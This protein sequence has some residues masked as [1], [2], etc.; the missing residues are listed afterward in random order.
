MDMMYICVY[1]FLNGYL[2]EEVYMRPPPGLSSPSGL[3]YHLRRALYGLKQS[4]R[5]WY[6]H[7][8]AV[9]LQIGFQ[10]SIHDSALFVCHTSHSL[11]LLLLYVDDMIITG[12][13]PAAISD[14][15]DHL[16]REFEMNDLG[17]LRY[18]SWN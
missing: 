1:A 14:I 9:V 13:D 2:L 5:A 3:V 16:F 12:S 8:H 4:P 17:P 10:P 18:F 6:A 7:F 11:V 15:K